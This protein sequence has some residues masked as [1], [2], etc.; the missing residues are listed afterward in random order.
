MSAK[1]KK[2]PSCESWVPDGGGWGICRNLRP[3]QDV[4]D[5]RYGSELTFESFGCI[6]HRVRK[7]KKKNSQKKR[8]TEVCPGTIRLIGVD[9]YVSIMTKKSRSRCRKPSRAGRDSSRA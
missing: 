3:A 9:E 2:C 6:Y 1:K 4:K 5:W 8:M 7:A